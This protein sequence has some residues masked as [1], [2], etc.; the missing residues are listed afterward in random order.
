MWEDPPLDVSIG[1]GLP[2][3]RVP[4]LRSQ[5]FQSIGPGMMNFD[6]LYCHVATVLQ[7]QEE[8]NEPQARER[9]LLA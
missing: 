4:P 9:R 8:G 5:G 3:E 2:V 7:R 6:L 1:N